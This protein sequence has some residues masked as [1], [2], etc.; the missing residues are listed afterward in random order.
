MISIKFKNLNRVNRTVAQL[1]KRLDEEVLSK[2]KEFMRFVLKYAKAKAP[3]SS[4]HL[5]NSLIIYQ[6]GKSIILST[7]VYYAK[8]VEFGF[9]PHII[10]IQYM[11]MHY[12]SPGM[13]GQFVPKKQISGF[14]HLS[15]VAQ[16]FL[17][18]ALEDGLSQLPNMLRNAI[19]TAV[20][21]SK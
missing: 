13:P 11:E 9:A 6:R 12:S 2:S 5:A 20:R 3:K 14:A 4:G 15:G 7:D 18:P 21:R 17:Y 10:P 1:G 16:P 19:L 8:F